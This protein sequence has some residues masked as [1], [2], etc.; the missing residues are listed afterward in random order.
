MTTGTLTQPAVRRR[1]PGP[2]VPLLPE[3]TGHRPLSG[4]TITLERQHGT[5]RV[6]VARR[7][8]GELVATYNIPAEAYATAADRARVLAG[9][10]AARYLSPVEAEAV[11]AE[12]SRTLTTT[13]VAAMFDTAV[14]TVQR[15][16]TREKILTNVAPPGHQFEFRVAEVRRVLCPGEAWPL[17]ALITPKA[18]RKILF[19]SD[20]ALLTWTSAG[21]L[22][23]IRLVSGHRRYREAEVRA[24]AA[25]L[26]SAR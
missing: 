22:S 21:R 25:T 4:H 10:H 13:Q 18:A 7:L 11:V 12:A 6:V 26:W 17:G 16:V 19:V 8:H 2:E 9:H 20:T 24:L 5:N 3:T 1:L 14:S 23:C 15:W